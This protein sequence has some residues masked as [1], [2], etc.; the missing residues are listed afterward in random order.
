MG[1]LDALPAAS[2]P[3]TASSLSQICWKNRARSSSE[4]YLAEGT[5]RSIVSVFRGYTATHSN[6]FLSGFSSYDTAWV[7]GLKGL[8][9]QLRGIGAKCWCSDRSRI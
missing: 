2:T 3:G 7:N 8:V 4:G 9:Q 6:G 1:R 5:D